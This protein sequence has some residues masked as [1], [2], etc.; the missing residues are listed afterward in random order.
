MIT[1]LGR[2]LMVIL[3][4]TASKA[5][6]AGIRLFS[7]ATKRSVRSLFSRAGTLAR[8]AGRNGAL[9]ERV[10]GQAAVWGS[11]AASALRAQR[12]TLARRAAAYRA[13]APKLL[14]RGLRPPRNVRESAW[15]RRVFTVSE[16]IALYC[17]IDI[18]FSL[19]SDEDIELPDYDD[20]GVDVDQDIA[21]ATLLVNLSDVTGDDR[22]VDM[23][24][25]EEIAAAL[26]ELANSEE[27]INA[28]QSAIMRNEGSRELASVIVGSYLGQLADGKSSEMARQM[29]NDVAKEQMISVPQLAEETASNLESGLISDW[30]DIGALV[31]SRPV[32]DV[33]AEEFNRRA[34]LIGLSQ[35]VI[36]KDFV[37]GWMKYPEKMLELEAKSD[38][39]NRVP[40]WLAREE[41]DNAVYMEA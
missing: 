29:I 14:R 1:W 26:G 30:S 25:P 15:A 38:I 31:R 36:I 37:A 9:R 6:G 7:R 12:A 34:Q 32:Y 17:G 33:E 40:E 3:S 41:R 20:L 16:T 5:A 2:A 23:E 8:S 22:W 10:V 18:L 11:R 39:I 21:L 35:Y 28:L 19:M 4:S 13:V 27:G 24:D